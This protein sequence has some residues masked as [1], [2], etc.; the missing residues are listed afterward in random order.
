MDLTQLS[1]EQ[2]ASLK[3]QLGMPDVDPL[4]RSPIKPR[5]L[6]DL[7]LLPTA[8][9]PRPTFFWSADPPRDAGDLTRTTEF[10]KLLF[11]P[12]TGEEITVRAK[13]HEAEK[14]AAG[15]VRVAPVREAPDPVEALRAE[16]EALSPE[17]R[18]E[19][20]E[21]QRLARLARLQAK[22]AALPDTSL[23][24]VM[25]SAYTQATV[26]AQPLEDAPDPSYV[27]EDPLEPARR[28]PGRPPKSQ[29]D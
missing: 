23:E 24:A 16:L 20:F 4:G 13:S 5:Q 28:K 17:D 27:I 26:P 7:R 18:A 10:P 6:N 8:D 25:G 22:V 1:P 29:G 14:L 21:G 15:Y 12:E 19:L 3:A 11:H 2:V 9:D